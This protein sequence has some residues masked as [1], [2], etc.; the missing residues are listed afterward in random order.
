MNKLDQAKSELYKW[1]LQFIKFTPNCYIRM[2]MGCDYISPRVLKSTVAFES[3]AHGHEWTRSSMYN[4]LILLDRLLSLIAKNEKFVKQST[5]KFWASQIKKLL[6]SL[7]ILEIW[8]NKSLPPY[9]SH[10]AEHLYHLLIYCHLWIKFIAVH[11]H[12]QFIEVVLNKTFW[13]NNNM[14]ESNVSDYVLTLTCHEKV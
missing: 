1:L 7:G 6:S 13:I 5:N 3:I 4:S 10:L 9:N 8:L 2:E 14:L 12:H 11:I